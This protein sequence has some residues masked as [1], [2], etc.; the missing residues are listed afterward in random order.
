[1]WRRWEHECG[2]F[3]LTSRLGVDRPIGPVKEL[4]ESVQRVASAIVGLISRLVR[5]GVP[6]M[7]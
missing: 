5:P 6:D 7:L 4:R 1:M 2:C 3:G